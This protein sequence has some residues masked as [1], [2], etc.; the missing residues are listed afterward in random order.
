LPPSIHLQVP[1]K[2]FIVYF[3]TCSNQKKNIK[4]ERRD[5]RPTQT[6]EERKRGINQFTFFYKN[7]FSSTKCLPKNLTTQKFFFEKKKIVK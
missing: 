2:I 5:A 4:K 7:F 1:Q 6:I 3:G